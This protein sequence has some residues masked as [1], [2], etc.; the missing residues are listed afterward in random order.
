MQLSGDTFGGRTQISIGANNILWGVASDSVCHSPN[1]GPWTCTSGGYF[2]IAAGNGQNPWV[3]DNNKTKIYR[4]DDNGSWVMML[5][6]SWPGQGTGATLRQIAVGT[7][8]DAWAI[9]SRGV[10]IHWAGG[11]GWVQE[12]PYFFGNSATITGIA[13][14]N[15]KYVWASAESPL[16]LYNFTP[17]YH[18]APTDSQRRWQ[19]HCPSVGCTTLNSQYAGVSVGLQDNSVYAFTS[20]AAG[21]LVFQVDESLVVNQNVAS[22]TDY[23]LV[24]IPNPTGIAFAQIAA[25]GGANGQQHGNIFAT[26]TTG[27]G[28]TNYF[29]S[30]KLPISG[31]AWWYV[32][33]GTVHHVDQIKIYNRDD[34][35]AGRLSNF[36]VLYYTGLAWS[37]GSDQTDTTMTSNNLALSIS[38]NF[39]TCCVMVQKKTSDYLNLSEVEVYGSSAGVTQFSEVAGNG[40]AS[41]TGSAGSSCPTITIPG[42]NPIHSPLCVTKTPED[43][44]RSSISLSIP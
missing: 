29:Y 12:Q 8:E 36:R 30:G 22:S 40:S 7:D 16:G 31:A 27:S 9:D 11:L 35:L 42:P 37:L 39:D 1:W 15:A 25:V 26:T 24:N 2:Q 5:S 44:I 10:V 32:D 14:R 33:F 21:G 13:V 41:T 28:Y 38:V 18:D 20:S 4:R 17:T 34:G 3:I 6:G 43:A 19:R 23:S